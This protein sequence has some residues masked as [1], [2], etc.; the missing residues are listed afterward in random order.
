VS[1]I[2]Y[3]RYRKVKILKMNSLTEIIKSEIRAKGRLNFEE[4]MELALYH[5]EYGYYT[6]GKERIGREGDFYTS[7]FVHAAFGRTLAGFITKAW[8]TI[9]APQNGV[10]EMG[11]G[12]GLLASD[13]LDAIQE[14]RP[15]LYYNAEYYVLERNTHSRRQLDEALGHHAEK[16]RFLSS[17]DDLSPKSFNGVVVSNELVDSFP[18]RRAI[19]KEGKLREIYVTL[20]DDE[21]VEITDVPSTYSLTK[22]FDSYDLSFNEGQQVEINLRAKEWIQKVGAMI[23]KGLV[24]T[25]DYGHLAPELFSP[26]RM[27][28]TYKCMHKHQINESPYINIGGQDITCHVDYSNLIRAGDSVG[29][30]EIKYTTQ[31]QFLIDWGILE[32]ME[33][34][35]EM[36]VSSDTGEE[37]KRAAIKTL[38]LPGQMGHSFKV[39]LQGKNLHPA[40]EDFY[41]ESPL[42]ISFGVT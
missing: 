36:P 29:L 3:F 8:E 31:G 16:V 4:F 13:I 1:D 40:K 28:G 15:D 21:F 41:P 5:P 23:N 24:L 7:P 19:W 37:K 10:I 11:A 6:S 12:K 38:F 35:V 42:K 30:E 2:I 39:L 14:E 22:Y 18:F 34:D 32:L 20:E 17:P 26:E 9:H 25:I 27:R 33:S